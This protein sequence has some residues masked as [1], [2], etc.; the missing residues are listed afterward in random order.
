MLKRDSSVQARLTRGRRS[1]VH[2][3]RITVA[4]RLV[5]AV[6]AVLAVLPGCDASWNVDAGGENAGS[7]VDARLFSTS[8]LSRYTI[9]GSL[10][11]GSDTQS[12]ARGDVRGDAAEELIL[13]QGTRLVVLDGADGGNPREISFNDNAFSLSVVDDVDGDRKDDL[14]L[15]ATDAGSGRILVV[16]G[17]GRTILDL[18]FAEIFRAETRPQFV[19]D[20]R[21]YFT[22]VS[23]LAI[24]PKLVGAVSLEGTAAVEWLHHMGPVPLGLA[25]GRDGSLYLSHRAVSRDRSDIPLRYETERA[26]HARYV[27]EPSGDL[28]FYEPFGPP[29]RE[30]RFIDGQISG[31]RSKPFD[32]T[33]DGVEETLMLVERVSEFYGGPALLRSLDENGEILAEHQGPERSDGDFG[34]FRMRDRGSREGDATEA[35][36]VVVWR[37]RGQVTLLNGALEKLASRQLPGEVHN[38]RLHAIGDLNGD[39]EM[40]VLLSD[41]NHL[42]VL[43]SALESRFSFP[44]QTRIRDLEVLQDAAGR[45][46]FAVLAERLFFLREGDEA[47]ASLLLYSEPPGARFTISGT[48]PGRTAGPVIHGLPPGRREVTAR[49]PGVGMQRRSVELRQG[50]SDTLVFSFPKQAAP[51][52]PITLPRGVPAEPAREY[53][54]LELLAHTEIPEGF[55][56]WG[57]PRDFAAGPEGDLLLRNGPESRFMVLDPDLRRLHEFSLPVPG[58]R[59]NILDDISGDGIPEISNDSRDPLPTAFVA[60]PSGRLLLET[61]VSFGHRS[62]LLAIRVIGDTLWTQLYTGYRLYPRALVGVEVDSGRPTFSY[63][64]S[65]GGRGLILQ[66]DRVY[67]RQYTVSNGAVVEYEDGRVSRDTEVHLHVLNREGEALPASREFPG[68]D[69]D[70][71]LDFLKWDADHDGSQELFALTGKDPSYYSGTPTLYRVYPDGRLE[72]LFSGP[73]NEL[74]RHLVVPGPGG[75]QLALW[76]RESGQL[77]IIGEDFAMVHPPRKRPRPFGPA[78]LDGD[79]EWELFFPAGGTLRVEQVDGD[80]LHSLTLPDDSVRSARV[81]DLDRDGRAELIVVGAETVAVFGY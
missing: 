50:G 14:V 47:R 33:G 75:E 73:E 12:L 45:A 59:C 7:L 19:R 42:H 38:T 9:A 41:H 21:I 30:A 31:V 62:R 15:G 58:G 27:L 78:N 61:V 65:H 36:I 11:A 8:E 69:L 79:R 43:D 70:G 66:E 55:T 35:R 26:R 49:L 1:L 28:R 22:A 40:N 3:R 5:L 67:L 48:G 77:Q 60:S 72:S 6:L 51:A 74:A 10:E 34:F 32:L 13:D 44:T 54:E 64:I 71:R 52:H 56:V 17:R 76:W 80:V 24:A 25:G 29:V 46:A 81:A 18:A 53:A 68:N 2:G 63:P 16:S 20:G 23:R 39:G 37:R 4:L 57:A